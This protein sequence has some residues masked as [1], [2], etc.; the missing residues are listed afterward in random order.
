M[1]RLSAVTLADEYAVAVLATDS[2]GT[3]WDVIS[4]RFGPD[5]EFMDAALSHAFERVAIDP[6]R[7]AIGGFSDGASCAL[8]LGLVN[9]DL[10]THVI[11]FSPGFIVGNEGRGKPAIYISHGTRDGVLPIDST[12]RRLV[13]SLHQAGYDVQYR[14]FPGSH[15][16]PPHI[17]REAFAWMNGPPRRVP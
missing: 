11:A 17:A 9:G 6:T 1:K 14:E 2:R 10:F 15:E 5:V 8:S 4:G 13:P 3:T 12:S 7:V 16:V